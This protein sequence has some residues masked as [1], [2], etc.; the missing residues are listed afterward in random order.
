MWTINFK[1]GQA[2]KK[3]DVIAQIDPRTFQAAYDQAEAKQ[4]Q[5]EA[6]LATAHQHAGS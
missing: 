3:G 2:V 6:S 5:D 1:E 4:K